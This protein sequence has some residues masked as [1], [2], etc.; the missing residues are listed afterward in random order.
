[1]T[2]PG[3]AATAAV[4]VRTSARALAR[5]VVDHLEQSEHDCLRALPPTFA[6]ARAD[7]EVRL[8]Q[9]AEAMQVDSPELFGDAVAW[10]HVALFHRGVARGFLDANLRSIGATLT[11]ELPADCAPAVDRFLDAG[12]AAA[13][14]AAD[15]L[16]SALPDGAP[17]VVA[18]RR[19]LLAILEGR[20]DDAIDIA[21]S[22][23]E[24]PGADPAAA[25]IRVHEHLLV[26]VQREVGRM[27]LMAEIPIADE[28]HASQV[29]RRVLEV[30]QERLPRPAAN[31]A[32]VLALSVGGDLHEIGI[33][34]VAQRLQLA[35]MR[36]LNLGAN[37]PASDLEW[38]FADRDF[39][40][41]ALSA[42]TLLNLGTAAETIATLRRTRGATCPPILVGGHPFRVL[43]DLGARIGADATAEDATAAVARARELLARR[44][45]T[46]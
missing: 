12:R 35:G 6:D 37:L 24:Q 15:D 14:T 3:A 1:M 20:G 16:P 18:A 44:T 41:V 36:V 22:E 27:W 34:I 43:P 32:S 10:Y 40:V 31:A 29:V 28:H 26:P 5:A 42:N 19:F 30:M 13:A 23:F 7:T 9:L 38:V 17:M 39:D 45:R 46:A 4:L 21:R 2:K 25:A 8:L 33:R 11:A